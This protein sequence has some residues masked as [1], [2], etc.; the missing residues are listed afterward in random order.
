M[1]L[2]DKVAVITGAG[3][4][5]GKAIA[6]CFAKEGAAVVVADLDQ[7]RAEATV[8]GIRAAAGT[9]VSVAVDVSRLAD[10]EAMVVAAVE[11]FG[12]LDILCN[13]AAIQLHKQ[14]A[15][16]HELPESAWDRTFAVNAKGVWLCSRAAIP[17]MLQHGGGSIINIA[18][19]TGMVGCAP[20]YT[21]YSSSKAAV[22]GLTR[23][24]AAEY[25]ADNIRVNAV[26]PGTTDTPLIGELLSDPA[27]R[28]GLVARALL[29]RLGTPEDVAGLAL[30]LASDDARYCT[31]GFYM[32][33][34]GLTA[35]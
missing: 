29:G 32:V 12:A 5:I 9:A 19:P 6:E 3:A 23:V 35:V 34:G 11:Q 10:T 30:F 28:A 27:V 25:G 14:D 13:N 31:G 26:V 18:S 20:G 7:S 16:A 4:G 15:R 24:M 2:K 21:A 8:A 22:F 1:R 33:D 17:H